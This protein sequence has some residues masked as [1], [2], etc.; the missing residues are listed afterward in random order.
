MNENDVLRQS[1]KIFVIGLIIFGIIGIFLKQTNLVLGFILGYTISVISFYIII[2]MSDIILK[3]GQAVKYVIFMFLL[4]MILYA[5]GFILAIKL[6]NL[7][8]LISVFCGYF[9]MKI[10]I[11]LLSYLNRE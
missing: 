3:M 5:G 7:F 6:D 8:S 4:K 11:G 1:V 9:V 2:L 10:T